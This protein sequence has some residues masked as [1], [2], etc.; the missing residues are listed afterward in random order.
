M[1]EK[2]SIRIPTPLSFFASDTAMNAPLSRENH[3][4]F[5]F[6]LLIRLPTPRTPINNDAIKA[7]MSSTNNLEL[8][9]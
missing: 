8:D 1:H 5:D 7:P 3:V 9:F 4:K 2:L 6:P